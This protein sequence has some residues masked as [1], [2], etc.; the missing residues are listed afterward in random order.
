MYRKLLTF[1]LTAVALSACSD[2]PD[3][4]PQL[5]CNDPAVLQ[6]VRN[7]IQ[8]IV[9]QEARAFAQSDSRQFVDTN[10]DNP[11][12]RRVTFF[13][14][15][16]NIFYLELAMDRTEFIRIHDGGVQEEVDPDELIAQ[17]KLA[18]TKPA[19]A[20]APASNEHDD[21]LDSLGI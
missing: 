7:N 8:E 11:E 4:T 21:L 6:S 20:V 14:A 17:A 12:T 3:N 16:N 15:S 2:K 10:L 9:K 19:Q 1:T 13:T 18:A 5:V